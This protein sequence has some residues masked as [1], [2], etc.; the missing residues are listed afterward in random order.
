MNTIDDNCCCNCLGL[1]DDLDEKLFSKLILDEKHTCPNCLETFDDWLSLVYHRTQVCGL[2]LK[3]ECEKCNRRFKYNY[4]LK[5]H[6]VVCSKQKL[7]TP[8]KHT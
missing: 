5:A 6:G 1:S 2:D 7:S 8:K 3:Y 4:N